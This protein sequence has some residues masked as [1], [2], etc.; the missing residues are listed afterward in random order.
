M[1]IGIKIHGI[2]NIRDEIKNIVALSH[3]LDSRVRKLE[4]YCNS[5]GIEITEHDR[6]EE[7]AP[8]PIEKAIEHAA[9]H[10]ESCDLHENVRI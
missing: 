8:E 5:A 2:K 4:D 1:D 7:F 9:I 10:A 3:E 6:D